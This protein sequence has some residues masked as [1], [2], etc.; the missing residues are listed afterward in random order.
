MQ[1]I[2]KLAFM[3]YVIPVVIVITGALNGMC[4]RVDRLGL[5][6]NIKYIYE[7]TDV[8]P[9]GRGASL[10]LASIIHNHEID[11]FGHTKTVHHNFCTCTMYMHAHSPTGKETSFHS[12]CCC[13]SRD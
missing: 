1:A 3:V 13:T 5:L 11:L 6:H 9:C 8:R 12:T 10:T 2:T 4:M 7:I